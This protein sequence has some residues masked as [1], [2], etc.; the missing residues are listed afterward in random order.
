MPVKGFMGRGPVG[1]LLLESYRGVQHHH[2]HVC[3]ANMF[4][5]SCPLTAY[6]CKF[7]F[8]LECCTCVTH[9]TFLSHVKL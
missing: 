5:K 9:V 6:I 3:G 4:A 7:G 8:L 1:L 2:K